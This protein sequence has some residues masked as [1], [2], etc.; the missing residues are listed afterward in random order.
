VELSLHPL[1]PSLSDL[2]ESPSGRLA[3]TLVDFAQRALVDQNIFYQPANETRES[4]LYAVG[5][6]RRFHIRRNP[7]LAISEWV[8]AVPLT[9]WRQWVSEV[10]VILKEI[11]LRPS[12]Q[13]VSI[14]T[15]Y[16]EQNLRWLWGGM[17]MKK[18]ARV[19]EYLTG[20]E[21]LLMEAWEYVMR[22][23]YPKQPRESQVHLDRFLTGMQEGSMAQPEGLS[24]TVFASSFS[25]KGESFSPFNKA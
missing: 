6:A 18:E 19:L 11:A 16:F 22:H 5:D 8:G 21:R 13:T 12:D 24:A 25:E 17:E 4:L 7:F 15:S 1:A 2:P 14:E 3:R 20:H 10:A 9:L 23:Y